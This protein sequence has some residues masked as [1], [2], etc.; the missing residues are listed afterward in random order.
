M[1]LLISTACLGQGEYILTGTPRMQE[2]PVQ[3]LVTALDRIGVQIE[4]LRDNGCPPVSIR[5]GGIRGGS[6]TIDCSLSSQFLSSL[7]LAAPCLDDGLDIQV[8]GQTVSKPYIDMTVD[9]LGRFGIRVNRDGY[10]CFRVPGGQRFQPGHYA[11]E[12]DISNASYFWAIGAVSGRRIT[13]EGIQ[14][15]SLQGDL[16][17]VTLFQQMGCQV[18]HS[19]DRLSVQGGDLC[20]IDADMG[21]LP[22]MVPTLAVVAA[23]ARGT[24]TIRNVA[25]LKAKECDRL[26]AVM[27]ELGRMGIETHSDGQT[28]TIVGGTPNGAE[29]ETYNDHRIAM[30]FAVA[31]LMAEGTRIRDE[32][33]VDKSFP[34]FWRVFAQVTAA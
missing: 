12:P 23:F 19:E 16:G 7:L 1:R 25:H 6:T 32:H 31:G 24:T 9:I 13:V 27:N 30:S 18:T 8:V 20:G 21:D 26:A 15:G 3:P 11:V 10:Q 34:D 14:P 29:I 2:R 28:L 4:C 22:D 33:C 5:G 17:I